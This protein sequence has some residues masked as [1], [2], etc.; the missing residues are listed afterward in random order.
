MSASQH[1]VKLADQG[2]PTPRQQHSAIWT[3]SEMIVWTG[4]GSNPAL[5][6][7]ITGGIY[8]PKTDSW[9]A[10]SP[11]TN[12]PGRVHHA[13]VWTG[14]AMLAWGG[15][16]EEGDFEPGR[17]G[18][19]Y[20]PSADAWST[21]T[22]SNVP[23]GR[24]DFGAVF[25]GSQLLVWGG[26]N[27][28]PPG[29]LASGARYDLPTDTWQPISS[30][31][32]P[33]PRF[34]TASVWTGS[35]MVS[36]GGQGSADAA[37]TGGS[38]DPASDGWT[39]IDPSGAPAAQWPAVV[40]SGREVLVWDGVAGGA[41]DPAAQRWRSITK[42]GAP[43]PRNLCSVVW[44]GRYMLVWGGKSGSQLV[45]DGAIYDPAA[46]RWWPMVTDGAPSPRTGH[47]AVWTG[48]AMIVWGGYDG[49]STVGDGAAFVP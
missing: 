5:G 9:R 49:T 48:D 34:A 32:A 40:W 19:R 17:L 22:K 13:T 24:S 8:V 7:L 33:S 29:Y 23:V 11:S 42:Q 43:S 36:W 12:V 30:S 20:D 16:N 25:T 18:G 44:T 41:Y 6:V 37:H 39:T 38:Y 2:A 45:G 1:W 28:L 14:A 31:G 15:T 21:L 10:I 47:S 46:D 35:A 4:I 26:A 27:D 3:G